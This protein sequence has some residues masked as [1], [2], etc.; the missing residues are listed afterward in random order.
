MPD[1]D[2]ELKPGIDKPRRG[3]YAVGVLV[4]AVLAAL[5]YWRLGH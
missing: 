4:I 3:Q 2:T 5:A 1:D